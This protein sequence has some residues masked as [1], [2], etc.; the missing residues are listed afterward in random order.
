MNTGWVLRVN[1]ALVTP[2]KLPSSMHKH[3]VYHPDEGEIETFRSKLNQL[4]NNG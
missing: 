2:H 4:Q 3:P 1:I